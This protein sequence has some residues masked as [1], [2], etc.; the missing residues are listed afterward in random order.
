MNPALKIATHLGAVA[1]G[2]ALAATAVPRMSAS[3]AAAEKSKSTRQTVGGSSGSM[4]L[5]AKQT[6]T[7][8]SDG[9]SAAFRAAWAALAKEPLSMTDRFAAQKRLLSEW[10][11]IDLHGA[12]QAYLGEAWDGRAPDSYSRNP[13]SSAFMKVFDQHPEQSW[14]VL[15]RDKMALNLLGETWLGS[16]VASAPA[17]VISVL[18]EMSPR[19][20][21][22]A[23]SRIFDPGS[24]LP[25][26]KREAMLAKLTAS[27]TPAQV[28]KWLADVYRRTRE[29]GDPSALAAKWNALP[30]G[31]ERTLQMAAW[32]SSMHAADAAKFSA[33][34]EK[35]PAKDRGQAARMLL[36][37]VDNE[38]P[39][40][41]YAIDRAVETE[42]WDAFKDDVAGKLRGFKTDRQA[43]AEWALKLPPREEIRAVYN[44]AISEKLLADPVGGRAWLEQLPAGDWHRES[45]FIEMT[46]GSLW[47][48]GDIN[49]ANRAIDAITDPRARE[50]ALKCRYDW[51]LLTSQPRILREEGRAR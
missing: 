29:T 49:A 2:A 51:Q 42:Q 44:L 9:R 43:L 14:A 4:P 45:G 22:D 19:L 26:D 27:G 30:V 16:C 38:S 33:E 35:V 20:Q 11:E 18:G 37:Q 25:A 3:S 8:A 46:L 40:L 50:E 47:A 5:Q 39:A 48:R 21:A 36:A 15:T 34:W 41:T 24:E 13:L 23:V 6:R 12:I 31:G 32:A 10:A 17:L 28:E 7:S 1:I